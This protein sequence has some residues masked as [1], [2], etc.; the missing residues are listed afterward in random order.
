MFH[1]IFS[2]LLLVIYMYQYTRNASVL[3]ELYIFIHTPNILLPQLFIYQISE[4]E[5]LPFSIGRFEIVLD[6]T[7]AT[8]G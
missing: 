1:V 7:M 3:N 5:I 4:L 6:L 8:A 2:I